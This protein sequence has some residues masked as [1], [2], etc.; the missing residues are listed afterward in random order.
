MA[1]NPYN[2]ST[3]DPYSPHYSGGPS[4]P[5][6]YPDLIRP[7]E[8]QFK[9]VADL[10]KALENRPLLNEGAP[11]PFNRRIALPDGT[12]CAPSLTWDAIVDR[13]SGRFRYGNGTF[14]ESVHCQQILYWNSQGYIIGNYQDFASLWSLLTVRKDHDGETSAD[15]QNNA[16]GTLAEA[17]VYA[18]ADLSHI[19][20]CHVSTT[21]D[22][23]PGTAGPS[24]SSDAGALFSSSNSSGSSNNSSSSAT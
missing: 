2:L 21:F 18:R 5:C 8:S 22:P 4:V 24:S 10:E 11:D 15:V 7:A 3:N 9:T 12:V 1:K 20:M 14:G 6:N 23:C 13:D 19:R 17:C 16:G